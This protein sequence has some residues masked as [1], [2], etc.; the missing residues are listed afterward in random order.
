MLGLTSTRTG[1]RIARPRW[2]SRPPWL[3]IPGTKTRVLAYV[4][5]VGG[6]AALTAALGALHIGSRE[7]VFAYMGVVGLLGFTY[8]LGPALVCAAA[9]FLFVDYYFVAP[10]YVFTL[11]DEQ[12][13][14]N[15]TSLVAA[16]VL[17]SRRRSHQLRAEAVAAMLEDANS[18][19]AQLNREQAAAAAARLDLALAHE[20]LE[21]MAR[22]ER[23]RQE[24]LAD[25]SHDLRTP[26]TSI[27]TAG[28]AALEDQGLLPETR[29]SLNAGIAEAWRLNRLVRDMLDMAT[30]DEHAVDLE[31][32]VLDLEAVVRSAAD[33][34]DADRA[35]P[36]VE[37]DL[38]A[39][40]LVMADWQR[41]A[42]VMDNLL[43]NADRFAPP[44]TS[45][46]VTAAPDLNSEQALIRVRDHGP[47]VSDDLRESVFDRFVKGDDSKGGTGLGLAIV[48]GLI[49]AHG[50]SIELEPADDWPGASFVFTLPLAAGGGV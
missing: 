24:F 32:E 28:T 35:A 16:A 15:L 25:V 37:I 11:V 27:I 42:Q 2:R 47:G 30:I 44:H 19:L 20:R 21:S 33:R 6:P 12:D 50:G 48:R 38:N 1:P 34:L 13:A 29:Q 36:R 40:I 8:G 9:S 3:P 26:I 14:F 5:A 4:T 43:S 41:L 39:E 46:R 10:V 7:Y 17:V 18:E 45:I 23:M 31:L 22:T 49:E